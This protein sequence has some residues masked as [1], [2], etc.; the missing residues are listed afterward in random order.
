MRRRGRHH[1]RPSL[2][3]HPLAGDSSA[4]SPASDVSVDLTRFFDFGIANSW[5]LRFSTVT[6]GCIITAL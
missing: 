2:P 5:L 4:A 3:H 1:R 6:L